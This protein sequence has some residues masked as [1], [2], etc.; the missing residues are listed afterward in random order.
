MMRTTLFGRGAIVFVCLVSLVNV[1]LAGGDDLD[2]IKRDIIGSW[3]VDVDTEKRFRTLNITGAESS[4]DGT[5]MLENTYGWT[6]GGADSHQCQ[7]DRQ[8]GRLQPVADHS[9]QQPYRS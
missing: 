4:P 6:D 5:W 8:A 3:L 7:V 1:C 2:R 9:G